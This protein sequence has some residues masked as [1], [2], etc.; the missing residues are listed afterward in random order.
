MAINVGCQVLGQG[1]IPTVC[2]ITDA[3]LGQIG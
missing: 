3:D 1:F 2:Q